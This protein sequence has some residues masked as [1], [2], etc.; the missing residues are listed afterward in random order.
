[1]SGDGNEAR[2]RKVSGGSR[3][4]KIS[5]GTIKAAGKKNRDSAAEEGD[6]EGGYDELLSAY[7]SEDG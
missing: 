5:S 4:R 2:I 3:S 1:M 7:E 6:D